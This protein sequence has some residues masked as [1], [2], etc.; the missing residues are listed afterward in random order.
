VADPRAARGL[1]H[2]A[3]LLRLEDDLAYNQELHNAVQAPT[4]TFQILNDGKVEAEFARINDVAE[5]YRAE[6]TII[7]DLDANK[8]IDP[9]EIEKVQ[10][11]YWDYWRDIAD[12]AGQ[13]LKEYL[14]VEMNSKTGWFQLWRGQEVDPEKVA[15]T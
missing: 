6:V 8:R 4:K 14:F 7:K 5:P 12:A 1:T 9:D 15:V 10:L 2:H 11:Q 3:L 13:P